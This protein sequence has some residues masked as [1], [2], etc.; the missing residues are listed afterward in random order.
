M[1]KLF[2]LLL[3]LFLLLIYFK[4]DVTPMPEINSDMTILALGDSVTYGYGVNKEQSYPSLLSNLLGINIINAGINGDTTED[5]LY[6]LP[7]L[8]NSHSIDIM[9]LFLGG[10]DI[11]QKKSKESIKTNLRTIILAVKEK[12]IRVILISV[13]NFSIF[14]LEPLSLYEELAEEEEI[15]L[16]EGVL[17]YVLSQEPLK[18]DYIHP[19]AAGYKYIADELYKY[20]QSH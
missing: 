5:A 13:P 6:R 8:L 1:N 18:S 7:S 19:N 3:S 10:N 16:V 20:L 11:L 12:N 2:L 4:K 15:D 9:L 14:G 17:A